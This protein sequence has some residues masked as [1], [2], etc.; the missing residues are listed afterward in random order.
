[1]G[2]HDN[3][4]F[5][6]NAYVHRVFDGLFMHV[7]KQKLAEFGNFFLDEFVTNLLEPTL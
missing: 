6:I 5:V 7:D 4:W 3:V 1:M 2:D